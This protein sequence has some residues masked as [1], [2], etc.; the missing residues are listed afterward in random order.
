MLQL[1]NIELNFDQFRAALIQKGLI[2]NIVDTDFDSF[3]DEFEK[4]IEYKSSIA[5]NNDEVI[6]NSYLINFVKIY[7]RDMK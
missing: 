7:K 5:K 3:Q 4:Y 6:L 2:D 1:Q